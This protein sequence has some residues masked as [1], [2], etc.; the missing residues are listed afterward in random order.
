MKLSNSSQNEH[1][2][3]NFNCSL[4]GSDYG[5]LPLLHPLLDSFIH[6]FITF[7]L[8]GLIRA[9]CWKLG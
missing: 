7:L 4:I 2:A 1:K 6:S 3:D 9:F 8:F 5:L